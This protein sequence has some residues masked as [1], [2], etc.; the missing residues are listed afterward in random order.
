MPV[1]ASRKSPFTP[2]L[3]TLVLAPLLALAAPLAG[4][5]EATIHLPLEDAIDAAG[6]AFA[7]NAVEPL[8]ESAT[9]VYALVTG[10]LDTGDGDTG[11][12]VTLSMRARNERETRARVFTDSPQNDDLARDIATFLQRVRPLASD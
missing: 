12:R 9:E 1:C 2:V 5:A 8:E 10:Q 4:A 11:T 3:L 6:D 7:A